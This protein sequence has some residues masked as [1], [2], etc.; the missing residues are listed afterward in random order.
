MHR[1]SV[2]HKSSR[3]DL[4]L[5]PIPF[6]F[7]LF[8]FPYFSFFWYFGSCPFNCY[9]YSFSFFLIVNLRNRVLKIMSIAFP[10]LCPWIIYDLLLIDVFYM[11]D[12]MCLT[13]LYDSI[14]FLGYRWVCLT[15]I[16]L[17]ICLNYWFKKIIL[18]VQYKMHMLHWFEQINK[19]CMLLYITLFCLISYVYD[20]LFWCIILKHDKSQFC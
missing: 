14:Y 7:S 2:N 4:V 12:R 11:K 17:I 9:E 13:C 20:M 15:K 18:I 19:T 10:F 3:G 6:L 1:D 8:L 5:L 16:C